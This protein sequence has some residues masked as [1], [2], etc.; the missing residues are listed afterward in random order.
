MTKQMQ[1]KEDCEPNSRRQREIG[2][3]GQVSIYY[4]IF[5]TRGELV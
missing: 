3:S 2:L 5:G 4:H 1:G